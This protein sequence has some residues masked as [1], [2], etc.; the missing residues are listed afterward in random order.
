M[1]LMRASTCS[2]CTAPRCRKYAG[3]GSIQRA[4]ADRSYQQRATLHRVTATIDGGPVVDVEPY[5]LDP[6]RPYGENEDRAYDAGS[7]L[8]LRALGYSE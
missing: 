8:L 4:L 2:T 1:C 7:R 6:A 5:S 3:L